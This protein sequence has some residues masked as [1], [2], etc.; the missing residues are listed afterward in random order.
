M[1]R[2]AAGD[3]V[4]ADFGVTSGREQGGARPA[5]VVSSPSHDRLTQGLAIVVPCTSRDRGWQSHVRVV[6]DLALE[7]PTFAITEQPRTI[8][9]ERIERRLGAVDPQCLRR[10]GLLVRSWMLRPPAFGR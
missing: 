9:Y 2:L 4:W 6:G 3:V 10:I 8:A 1:T 5:V 7:V